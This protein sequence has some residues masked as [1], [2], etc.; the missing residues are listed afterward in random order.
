MPNDQED[1]NL[2]S[3]GLPQAD[4]DVQTPE[5][6]GEASS[7]NQAAAAGDT[8]APMVAMG[9]MPEGPQS[10]NVQEQTAAT[11]SDEP[12]VQ[13]GGVNAPTAAYPELD[14]ATPSE[15]AAENGVV[16]DETPS[17][18][19]ELPGAEQSSQIPVTHFDENAG[20]QAA[21][22]VISDSPEQS[23]SDQNLGQ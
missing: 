8:T 10:V 20:E 18:P 11:V 5:L 17:E 12:D 1:N 9:D 4:L 22:P 3:T 13:S 14:S 2:Q 19:V 7:T 21:P 6:S 15:Q 16:G 23:G